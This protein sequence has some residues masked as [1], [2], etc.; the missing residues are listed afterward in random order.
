VTATHA[1]SEQIATF[2]AQHAARLRRIVAGAVRTNTDTI[3]DACQ[4]AWTILIRRD[5]VTLDDRGAAWLT[6]VAIHEAFRLAGG[7]R[8]EAPAG[9]FLPL[10]RASESGELPEPERPGL[11]V[12]NQVAARIQLAER[13]EDLRQLKPQD[14][15]A[16]YL[17]GMAYSYAEI[18]T[19]T[20]A[21]YTAV[22]RRITEGRAELRRRARERAQSH[23]AQAGQRSG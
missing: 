7:E 14:R 18:M 23:Q 6:K 22:N 12:E 15:L 1:R 10:T 19:M 16:L 2:Y 20:D 5:D 11:D 21:T 13:R 17:K 8:T 9:G 4:T 3:E